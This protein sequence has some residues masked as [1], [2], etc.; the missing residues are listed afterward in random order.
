MNELM[1]S[2]TNENLTATVQGLDLNSKD[3]VLAVGGSGDQAFA[4]LEFARRVIA[5]DTETAQLEFMKKRFEALKEGDY[6]RFLQ[7]ETNS[8]MDCLDYR[9]K[10]QAETYKASRR[11]YFLENERLGKIR[12]KIGSI[13][14][15]YGD[16][17][18]IA[19][20]RRDFSK[21]Y[22]SNTLGWDNLPYEDWEPDTIEILR[23][24]SINLRKN[25]LIYISNFH[26][27]NDTKFPNELKIDEDL[28][29]KVQELEKDSWCHPCVL[30]KVD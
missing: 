9:R 7:E 19:R 16:I 5:I 28:T 25:G 21:I 10:E 23:E 12:D 13:T 2:V 30:R 24:I 22:L 18:K 17:L 20:T 29:K 15:E 6:E 27:K 4:I 1:Y 8:I 26:K 14:F 11:K 3:S